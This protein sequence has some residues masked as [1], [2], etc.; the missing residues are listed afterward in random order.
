MKSKSTQPPPPAKPKKPAIPYDDL[1][2]YASLNANNQPIPK[3][4]AYVAQ[5]LRENKPPTS[6]TLPSSKPSTSA[7]PMKKTVIPSTSNKLVRPSSRPTQSNGH[8]P[9]IPPKVTRPSVPPPTRTITNGHQRSSLP[10]NGHRL[11]PKRPRI[12]T[13]DEDEDDEGIRS[14][15]DE[16]R[17]CI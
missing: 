15:T 11:P 17:F 1:M 8:K 7:P 4:L 14:F 5:S 3:E 6:K 9:V 12:D 13:D 10:V 2:R 16:E